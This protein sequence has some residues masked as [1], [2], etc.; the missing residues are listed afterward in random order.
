MRSPDEG[1]DSVCIDRTAL[2]CRR[3]T[4]GRWVRDARL[5]NLRQGWR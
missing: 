1:A 4:A 2:H 5:Y 3:D